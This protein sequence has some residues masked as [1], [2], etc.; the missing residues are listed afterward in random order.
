[1]N[2]R[3]DTLLTMYLKVHLDSKDKPE[4]NRYNL[5]KQILDDKNLNQH[6]LVNMPDSKGNSPLYIALCSGDS[7]IFKLLIEYGADP[8]KDPKVIELIGPWIKE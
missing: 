8:N 3:E 6:D 7:K 1:M 5:C 2:T 4:N